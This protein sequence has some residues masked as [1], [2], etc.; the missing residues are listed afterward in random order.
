MTYNDFRRGIFLMLLK[1]HNY[2]LRCFLS[3]EK[4]NLVSQAMKNEDYQFFRENG[5]VSLRRNID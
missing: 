4:N 5:N 2:I 3:I 1:F